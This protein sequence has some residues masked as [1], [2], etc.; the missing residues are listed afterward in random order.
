MNMVIIRQKLKVILIEPRISLPNDLATK[1]LKV[2]GIIPTKP[3]A[4]PV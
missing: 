3:K 4:K 2:N 1:K